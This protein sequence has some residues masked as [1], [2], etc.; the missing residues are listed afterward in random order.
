MCQCATDS[1]GDLAGPATYCLRSIPHDHVPRRCTIWLSH[2]PARRLL[3]SKE[4]AHEMNRT[5]G[6]RAEPQGQETAASNDTR[7]QTIG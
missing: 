6:N 5:L 3:F 1:G 2:L 7:V 4:I